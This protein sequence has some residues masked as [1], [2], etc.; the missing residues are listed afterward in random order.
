MVSENDLQRALLGALPA[1]LPSLRLFRRMVGSAEVR[2]TTVSFG[3]K[4]QCDL[5]GARMGGQ[6]VE[7]ELKSATGKMS[8][9]QKRWKTWCVSW[10]IQ[11]YCLVARR[12]ETL[13]QT[14]DR[15]IAELTL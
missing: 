13:S 10:G 6:A 1:R 4:G 2:G 8:E 11:H 9:E 12:N 14:M 5:H 15:W 3:L 7:V